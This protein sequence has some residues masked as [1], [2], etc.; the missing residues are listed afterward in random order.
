[1]NSKPTT[2]PPVNSGSCQGGELFAYQDEVL[3]D[4]RARI[5]SSEAV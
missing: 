1:M 3:T 5:D 4:I 2:N